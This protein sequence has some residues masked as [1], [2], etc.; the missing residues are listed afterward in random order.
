VD[1]YGKPCL[2]NFPVQVSLAVQRKF[3]PWKLFVRWKFVNWRIYV[4]NFT[5]KSHEL[6]HKSLKNSSVLLVYEIYCCK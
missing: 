5:C 4:H 6:I 1:C 2:S 3:V